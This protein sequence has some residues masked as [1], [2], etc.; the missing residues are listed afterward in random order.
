MTFYPPLQIPDPSIRAPWLDPLHTEE[1]EE[2]EGA[3]E[4]KNSP[5][6]SRPDVGGLETLS[7]QAHAGQMGLQV[8]KDTQNNTLQ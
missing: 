4:V 5:C 3:A 1:S 7:K 8:V 2:G 6:Q